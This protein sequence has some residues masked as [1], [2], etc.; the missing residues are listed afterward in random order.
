MTVLFVQPTYHNRFYKNPY[1]LQAI[2]YEAASLLQNCDICLCDRDAG[3]VLPKECFVLVLDAADTTEQDLRDVIETVQASKVILVED[4][5]GYTVSL[6]EHYPS[7]SVSAVGMF[8]AVEVL[9]SVVGGVHHQACADTPLFLTDAQKEEFHKRGI[10][11]FVEGAARGCEGKCTFCRMSCHEDT[12]QVCTVPYDSA[13]LLLQAEKMLG[14][15]LFVQ[16]ADE[17]FF[18]P[19]RKRLEKAI[20]LAQSLQQQQFGGIL[21]VDTRL[22]T[23]PWGDSGSNSIQELQRLCWTK[24]LQAGLKYCFVGIETFSPEQAARYSKMYQPK[25]IENAFAFFEKNDLT[26]TLGLI[27]WDPLM[28]EN[29]LLANLGC[30]RS[31]NLLGKTASLLKPLR[32][33][34]KSLYAQKYSSSLSMSAL[35]PG[36]TVEWDPVAAVYVDPKV[37]LMGRLLF[38]IYGIFDSAGYR[39]SDVSLFA[40][41]FNPDTPEILYQIPSLIADLEVSLLEKVLEKTEDEL[42]HLNYEAMLPEC[43]Y[44]VRRIISRLLCIAEVPANIRSIYYYYLQTFQRILAMLQDRH[45][46]SMDYK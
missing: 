40:A 2:Y 22:D 25:R 15:G 38:P 6:A 31:K 14:K 19:N 45:G 7:R 36:G 5:A 43:I 29:D 46:G 32:I 11:Y 17:N 39:H 4:M 8:D 24:M 20:Q 1:R 44:V 33:L 13:D 30:I 21:G 10:Q 3:D 42:V 34:P 28:T 35:P 18:G 37:R 23:I 12:A 9:A 41:R 26:F 16:F 27:L